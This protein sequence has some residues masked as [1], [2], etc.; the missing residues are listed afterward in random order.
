MSEEEEEEGE[1]VFSLQSRLF[2][3]HAS[4]VYLIAKQKEA[5]DFRFPLQIFRFGLY[6]A[7][8]IAVDSRQSPTPTS[9]SQGASCRG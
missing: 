4:A 9:P 7:L 5:C 6:F 2:L 1:G 3:Y 8:A